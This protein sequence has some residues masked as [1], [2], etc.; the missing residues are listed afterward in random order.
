MAC[1]PRGF[2][3]CKCT[4]PYPR[5]SD[6]IPYHKPLLSQMDKCYQ[7][8]SIVSSSSIFVRTVK[9]L[10]TSRTSCFITCNASRNF[11]ST[12]NG[13]VDSNTLSTPQL[14]PRDKSRLY[15]CEF[16]IIGQLEVACTLRLCSTNVTISTF[17]DFLPVFIRTCLRHLGE[18][19][20]VLVTFVLILIYHSDQT[21][22]LRYQPPETTVVTQLS[23]CAATR[24]AQDTPL[25]ST[26]LLNP[27]SA[28]TANAHQT[29]PA[30]LFQSQ[31]RRNL[32]KDG[33]SECSSERFLG[34]WLAQ[35]RES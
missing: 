26:S 34:A 16:Y 14:W 21:S 27:I 18:L 33:K 25:H 4:F 20:G 8:Q 32:T 31:P 19:S 28:V 17:P 7:I 6:L 29:F 11:N 15:L 9:C 23:E 1:S 13:P 5:S 10:S 2:L 30:Q 22:W 24:N 12:S 35:H 3:S